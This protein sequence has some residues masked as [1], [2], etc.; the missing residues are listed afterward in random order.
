M[1]KS[2]FKGF[3]NFIDNLVQKENKSSHQSLEEEETKHSTTMTNPDSIFGVNHDSVTDSFFGSVSEGSDSMMAQRVPASTSTPA[4]HLPF[5]LVQ[6]SNCALWE[7]ALH[8]N[9]ELCKN[10]LDSEIHGEL[11]ADANSKDEQEVTALHI[12]A[13]EGFLN[14]CEILLDYGLNTELN[15]MNILM[16][17][18]LH[19]ACLK[20]HLEVAQLLVRSGADINLVDVDGNTGI[21]LAAENGHRQLVM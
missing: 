6:K 18:P 9:G 2:V 1:E 17:T 7:A 20:N 21:H 16:R 11:A 5:S 3:K 4:T 14:I 12:A 8:N 10:L 19:L 15:T 13:S